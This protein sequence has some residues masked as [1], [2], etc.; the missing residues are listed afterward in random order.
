MS[1]YRFSISLFVSTVVLILAW[2]VFASVFMP[3]IIESAYRGESLSFLNALIDKRDHSLER[4][5][6]KWQEIAWRIPL[7]MLGFSVLLWL[8]VHPK[9]Q[10]L[11][12]ARLQK[13]DTIALASQGLNT[14]GQQRLVTVRA[15]I[16]CIICLSLL[17]ITTGIEIW[18]FSHY[19]MYS[20][21]CQDC[22]GDIKRLRWFGLIPNGEEVPL[23]ARKHLR[24]FDESRLNLSLLKLERRPKGSQLLDKALR[25]CLD[26]YEANR[27][28]G[29]HN[30]PQLQGLRLYRLV[31][32]FD[33]WARNV[34]RPKE[35]Q[36]I[37]EIIRH[38]KNF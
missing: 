28:A 2:I 23:S 7:S 25:N 5:L 21:K 3:P 13:S 34:D 9:I 33:P 30:D 27:L 19:S 24:P 26:V 36:L 20:G 29:L 1:F 22:V 10:S 11:M 31:W 18:P 35:K 6:M 38:E 12:E 4:Y 17:A 15:L 32:A 16:I 8:L 37:Y 14:M